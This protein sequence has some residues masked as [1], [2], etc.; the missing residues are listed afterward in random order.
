[1]Y[2]Y[3][4]VISANDST[5]SRNVC[6]QK[7]LGTCTCSQNSQ[8]WQIACTQTKSKALMHAR[9]LVI[10]HTYCFDSWDVFKQRTEHTD[11][12]A[13]QLAYTFIP[14]KAGIKKKERMYILL[15]ISHI[16]IALIVCKQ[17][18]GYELISQ[19]SP[20]A[21]FNKIKRPNPPYRNFRLICVT[22]II[23]FSGKVIYCFNFFYLYFMF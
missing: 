5:D 14:L 7:Q 15:Q 4:L 9:Q 6:E 17:K 12:L 23:Q 21:C 22:F 8:Q 13:S 10:L 11:M 18:L 1:M 20:L 19:L 2:L 3:M 16:F